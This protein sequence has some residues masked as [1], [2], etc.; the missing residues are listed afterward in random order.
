MLA[1]WRDG[2]T[3]DIHQ[4]MMRL[5][6]RIVAK[7]LFSIE[8]AADTIRKN[9]CRVEYFAGTRRRRT[10]AAASILALFANPHH[11]RVTCDV[12]ANKS[13]KSRTK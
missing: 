1:S 11:A 5:T 4:D 12:P 9:R 3:R 6:L 10:D 7:V 2:E 13:M 8:G